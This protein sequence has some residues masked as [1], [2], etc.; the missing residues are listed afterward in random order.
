MTAGKYIKPTVF[1]IGIAS[2]SPFIKYPAVQAIAI[3]NP[4]VADVP[5]AILMSTLRQHKY[6]TVNDPPPIETNAE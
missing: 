4:S 1:S 3:G 5:L 2:D 6:G